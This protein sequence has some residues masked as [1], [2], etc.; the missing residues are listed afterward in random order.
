MH[1][2]AAVERELHFVTI[3]QVDRLANYLIDPKRNVEATGK[4][5]YAY[6]NLG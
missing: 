6:S 4:G 5:D 2:T 3:L 1:E